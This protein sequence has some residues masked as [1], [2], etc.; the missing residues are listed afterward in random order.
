MVLQGCF[1][2]LLPAKDIHYVLK[3][4]LTAE[5]PRDCEKILFGMGCFW[6]A[7]RLFWQLN[8][9]ISTSVGF[10][11]GYK[12]KPFVDCT[13][14]SRVGSNRHTADA[15][16]VRVVYDPR[17]ICLEEL[18]CVFWEQH[19]PTQRNGQGLDHGSQYRTAIFVYTDGQYE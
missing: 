1:N 13:P 7:E 18:L 19:D 12:S 9:V 17:I 3:S 14:G 10:A 15:E 6:G 16:A 11:G 2:M 8:G 5:P 4:S